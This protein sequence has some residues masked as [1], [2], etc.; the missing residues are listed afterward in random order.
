MSKYLQSTDINQFQADQSSADAI[1]YDIIV[2][3]NDSGIFSLL[4][5]IIDYANPVFAKILRSSPK[6]IIGTSILDKV[7][8]TDRQKL[9]A[10]IEKLVSGELEKFNADLLMKSPEEKQDIYF[11]LHL[12]VYKKTEEGVKII[13]TSRESTLRVKKNIELV[14]TKSRFEALYRNII[15]GVIIYNYLSEEVMDCNA[16]AI[17]ILEFENRNEVL[18]LKRSKLIPRYSEYFPDIDLHK[19]SDRHGLRVM[20]GEAFSSPG[21]FLS[22]KGKGIL[23]NIN[24]VPTFYRHGE[25]FV[26]FQDITSRVINKK[27]QRLNEKK[28]RDIFENSHEAIIYTDLQTMRPII[29][30]NKALALFGIA[31]FKAFTESPPDSFYRETPDSTHAS[32][33]YKSQILKKVIEEGRAEFSHWLKKAS[34]EVIQIFGILIRDQGDPE[35]PKMISF[36]RD[37]TH[38]YQAL[39]DL[40]EKN[41]E[42]KKY[43]D[44]NLQLEN[45]AYFASHDLQTPLRSMISFTQLLQRKLTGRLSEEEQEYMDFIISSC[46]NMRNLVN[47]LLSYS[48]LNTKKIIISNI[49]LREVLNELKSDLGSMLKEFDATIKFVNIPETIQGDS[50]KIRQIFQNLLTNALKFNRP[51]IKPEVTISCTSKINHWLFSV[52][53]NGIGIAPEF[54][55]KIFLLFK[56]LHT[57]EQYEGTGI[58]LAM[59]KKIVEQHQG[60]IWLESAEGEGANFFFTIKKRK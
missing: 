46:K 57:N 20:R 1:P 47:D 54:Q 33:I 17:K 41:D 36:L 10:S 59:V 22:K 58:G 34:G 24:I 39:E 44:S 30:N 28:Y 40:N 49:D 60:E 45:F 29:C 31:N 42:L 15:D 16:A 18:N 38:L 23:V 32:K 11:S 26:I 55:K 9:Q 52:K 2:E 48:R 6:E 37:T 13:G 4:G 51:G 8:G 5:D 50:I 56:R 7:K 35:N 27:L 12:K 53:D 14:K 43:I 19:E 21:I 25:A 3:Q